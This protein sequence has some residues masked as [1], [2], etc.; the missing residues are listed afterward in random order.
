MGV[1]PDLAVG[2]S[3]HPACFGAMSLLTRVLLADA[4]VLAI[5]TLL[6]REVIAPL[7]R[8]TA[9]MRSV[10]PLQPG[11]RLAIRGTGNAIRRGL[12]EP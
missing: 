6:L 9:T 10:E 12:V 11:R 5:A 1:N 8:L 4:V 3:P 7:R 2:T